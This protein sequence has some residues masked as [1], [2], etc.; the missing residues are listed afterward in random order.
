MNAKSFALCATV[1]LLSMPAGG[2][3][4]SLFTTL[5]GAWTGSGQVK[6]D[7]GKSEKIKCKG[8]Y[9]AKDGGAKLGIAGAPSG[10]GFRI[11]GGAGWTRRGTRA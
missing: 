1:A 11:A 8:Y 6:L 4:R 10:S 5:D 7:N 3:N 9:N 2:Q